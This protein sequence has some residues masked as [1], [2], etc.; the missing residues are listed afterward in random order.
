[1]PTLLLLLALP[2]LIGLG[3]W[4][5]DRAN[6]REAAGQLLEAR[7]AAPAIALPAEVV[8]TESL[9][10]RHVITSGRY[11]PAYQFF[12]DNRV[13]HG[14]AGYDVITPLHVAGSRLRV[15]VNRG[16]IPVPADR[17]QLPNVAT[18]EEPVEVDGTAVIPPTGTFS[19]AQ[20]AERWESIWQK[21][22]LGR[23]QRLAD[24]PLQPVVIQLSP[25][26][27]AAG[28]VR[29]WPRVDAG[30]A[31]NLGYA[32]QWFGFAVVAVVLWLWSAFKPE[33]GKS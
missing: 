23:F 27:P 32:V 7:A 8:S 4:Q 14:Q 3:F 21:L 2:C 30:V 33:G 10:D 16:W 15:L 13:W 22:D 12:L 25:Q 19:L 24:M 20:P 9:R 1:M 18:P 26:S 11:E 6:G 29:E 17:R 28:F 5:L 31:R